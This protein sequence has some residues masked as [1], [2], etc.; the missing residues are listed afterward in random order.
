MLT[1]PDLFTDMYTNTDYADVDQ[2]RYSGEI[3]VTTLQSNP[4]G[5]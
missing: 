2:S 3:S 4:G 1:D 5:S